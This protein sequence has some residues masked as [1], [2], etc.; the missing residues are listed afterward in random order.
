MLQQEP[1]GGAIVCSSSVNGLGG[2][3]LAGPYCVA[4]TG[5]LSLV[6]TA[7]LE[8]A[9]DRLCGATPLD[10]QAP[11]RAAPQDQR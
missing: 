10:P 3:P 4:K 2:W 5:I 6:K 1:K 8:H 7:A 9:L 11:A